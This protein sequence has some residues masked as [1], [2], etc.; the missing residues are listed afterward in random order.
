MKTKQQQTFLDLANLAL[1]LSLCSN[2]NLL[3]GDLCDFC[4][5][6]LSRTRGDS[7]EI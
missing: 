3:S 7:A 4:D 6:S 5:S 1:F 2:D